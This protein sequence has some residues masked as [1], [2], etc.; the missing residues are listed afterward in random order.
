MSRNNDFISCLMILIIVILFI[1]RHCKYRDNTA[2]GG[3]I[4]NECGAKIKCKL[5]SKYISLVA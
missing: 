5:P 2:L 4:I 3:M 1:L